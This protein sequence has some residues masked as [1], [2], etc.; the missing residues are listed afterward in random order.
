[1]TTAPD[2]SELVRKLVDHV[3]TMLAYWG[4]DLRCKFANKAYERWFGLSPDELLGMSIRELLG[5]ALFALNEPYIQGALS[6]EEQLFE[7]VVPGPDGIKRHAL[8]SYVPDVVDGQIM[9]FIAQ[10]TE[11]TVLKEVEAA[12]RHEVDEKGRAIYLLQ[13]SDSALREAQRLSQIGSWEWEIEPDTTT[14]SDE[15]FHM[16]GL[17]PSSAGPPVAQQAALFTPASWQKLTDILERTRATGEPYV[18]E[19]EFIRSDR[20][21]GW[22]EARGEAIRDEHGAI[23]RLRGTTLDI[24]ARRRVEEARVQRDVA[25]A[26]N[27][28]KTKL[29]SRV[30]HE[31]RTPLNGILGYAQLNL[32]DSSA[33]EAQ[34]Q[35]SEVILGCGEHMLDLINEILDLSMAEQGHLKVGRIPVVV[36][37]VMAACLMDLAPMA[38]QA[39]VELVN[40][41]GQTEPLLALADPTRVR[42]VINNL[43]SNAIKYNHPGGRVTLSAVQSECHLDIIVADTGMGM[44]AEQLARLFTPFDRLGAETSRVQGTGVGLALSRKLVEL[45]GGELLVA[46]QPSHGSTVT[47]RLMRSI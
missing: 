20:T 39:G 41:L 34:R 14:W 18:I 3:P 16:F 45:M 36:Q 8:A 26:A 42:Q 30:S 1:M 4:V 24:T 22:M 46:S 25:E 28:N 17:A 33:S 2:V 19:L 47:F 40:H 29:L 12:L 44:S 27:L 10:V 5:P 13:K 11:V 6:G 7:R 37:E 21:T 15:L 32:L 43:V 35:R 23:T 9:G 38:T 31:L